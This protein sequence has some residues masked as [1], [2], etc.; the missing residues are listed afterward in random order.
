MILRE[1]A[2]EQLRTMTRDS[3]IRIEKGRRPIPGMAEVA[4][5]TSET[6]HVSLAGVVAAGEPLEAIPQTE[7][8]AVPK[9]MVG[10][11]ETFALRVKGSSMQDEGIFP[12]DVVVVQKQATARNGQTVIALVNG[13]ATIKIYQR[14]GG[15][16]ELHPANDSM[17]PILV[18]STDSFQIEGV[19][20]GVIRHLR[21]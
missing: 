21:K 5:S 17:Q 8:V 14:K 2:A 12:G 7:R 18:L 11:G 16:V 20:V 9:S 15:T 1:S 6:A 19:V 4:F 13:D 10:R 3:M